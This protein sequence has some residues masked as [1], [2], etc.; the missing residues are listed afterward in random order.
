MAGGDGVG[1]RVGDEVV[2]MV[3]GVFGMRKDDEE[4]EEKEGLEV[5][6]CVENW[7]YSGTKGPSRG[8]NVGDQRP[9]GR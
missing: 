3:G 9:K 4:K 8:R 1:L 6:L 7:D 5:Y 2:G